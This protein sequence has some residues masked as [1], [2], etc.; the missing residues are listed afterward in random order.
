VTMITTRVLFVCLG[1][2]CRSPTAEGVFRQRVAR[3]GLADRIHID[4][5]GTGDWHVGH[6]PDHRAI[7][8]ARR[9]GY[10]LS[11]LRARQVNAADFERFG[12]ILAMDRTNLRALHALRPPGFAG[13]L[14]L[15]LDFVP[16]DA[17]DE[18]PDPYYAGP[19]AF[20]HVLDLAERGSEAL[21]AALH[22]HLVPPA[23][24]PR[25]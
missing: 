18:V 13:H 4:S 1:N 20:D 14:G 9:R 10:D 21:L 23:P 8:A 2:I 15:F 6:P 22:G 5:A 3:A 24:R 12:W 7:A 16:D 11:T 19:E 17:L 25:R